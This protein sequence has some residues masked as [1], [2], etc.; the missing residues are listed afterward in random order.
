MQ[1][2]QKQ[3]SEKVSDA[4]LDQLPL[5]YYSVITAMKKL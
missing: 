3:Q 5:Y 4:S 2:R 1:I